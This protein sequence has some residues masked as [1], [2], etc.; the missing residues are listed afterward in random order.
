MKDNLGEFG[1]ILAHGLADR[2]TTALW[3]YDFDEQRVLWANKAALDVWQ[4]DTIEALC[5]R[6]LGTDMSPAVR[7]R[8]DQYREDFIVRDA[9]FSELWTLYPSGSAV[10]LRVIFRGYRLNDGRMAM[11]CEGLEIEASDPETV[12]SADALLHTSVMISLF[13]RDGRQLY[14][15]PA[16]RVAYGGV[17]RTLADQ[18]SKPDDHRDGMGQ[19]A[20][21]WHARRFATDGVLPCPTPMD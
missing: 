4:A 6:D 17:P 8:L 7:Q 1:T 16:A 10:T 18:F 5:A 3:V 13:H 20:R 9:E 19:A 14:R 11:L 2:L 15:N 12:R 21:L